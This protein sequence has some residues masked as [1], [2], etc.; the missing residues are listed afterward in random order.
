MKTGWPIDMVIEK[1]GEY[2]KPT[3]MFFF[4]QEE[5]CKNA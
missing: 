3:A 5:M 4:L 2:D 1:R